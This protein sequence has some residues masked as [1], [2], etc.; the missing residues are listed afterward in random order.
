MINGRRRSNYNSGRGRNSGKI[1]FTWTPPYT[2]APW[3]A[4]FILLTGAILCLLNVKFVQCHNHHSSDS[5]DHL[6]VSTKKGLVRGITVTTPLGKKVD[7]FLGIPYAMAP[8]G[9]YRFRHPKP[10]DPWTGVFNAS[11]KPNACYQVTDTFFGEDF[12]GS[13]MWNPNTPLS[14]DCLKINIW[15]P[16]PRSKSQSLAVLLWVFGGG[17]YSGSASLDLYDGRILASE[18]NIIV[19]SINYRVASLGFLFLDHED[20][21][22]NAGMFDQLMA[23]QWVH[24]NIAA[25]GGNPEN[26][27]L[28]GE[29]AGAVSVA[30]HL[31]SPLS[32]NFFSQAI[33][34]S[35]SAACPWG[36]IDHKEAIR[37]SLNLAKA[38]G[39]PDS[40]SKIDL[41]LDCLRRVHPL[42]L[43]SNETGD[44]GVAEFLFVPIVDGS[45]LDEPPSVSLSS[46]NF[47]KTNILIG[48]NQD[49]GNYFIVFY[50]SELFKKTE[51]VY[52]SREDFEKTVR[53]LNPTIHKIGVSSIIYEYTEWLDP[54]DA[55]KNRDAVDKMVGDYS[56]TCPCTEMAHRYSLSGCNVYYYYFNH[57]SSYSP[58]PKWMG[59]LHGDEIN[60]IFGEPLEPKYGYSP[61]EVELSRRMMNYW[62]NFAKTGSVDFYF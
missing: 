18:E 9:K 23:M 30:F 7:A 61:Q 48:S 27:T 40:E 6:L 56:F 47:K 21:P 38:V 35:G 8:I 1:S 53:E 55:I 25:F 12:R 42:D 37:R 50:L 54:D 51:E 49:E 20:A 3:T 62:A 43:V 34:Q 24:E 13:V 11:V 45:F 2:G 16:H 26:I 28:F 36:I 44:L 22:G 4:A 39:C 60:F 29:S 17:F 31:L 10:I 52:I 59:V 33:M 19:I 58:W 5:S 46:R 41:V 14:E 57:R 32:R 15:V